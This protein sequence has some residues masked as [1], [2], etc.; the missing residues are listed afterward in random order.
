MYIHTDV[1]A[2]QSPKKLNQPC[3][4]AYGVFRDLNATTIVLADGLGS[5]VKAHIAA[6][7]C[8]SRIKG[9]VGEGAS[10]REVFK[11]VTQTMDKAWGSGDPFAV[12]TVARILNTGQATILSYEMPPPILVNPVYAQILKDRV[13][14]QKKAIIH[15]SS[16]VLSK[17]EG[18]LLMSDGITQAGIGGKFLYGW[19]SEGVQ[20]YVESKLNGDRVDGEELVAQVHA[21]GRSYW[22]VGKGDDCS[23]VLGMNR[24]GVIVNLVCGPPQ[25]PDRDSEFAHSF[26]R[27][28]GIHI[29][30]GGTTAK[31][32]ANAAHK[33]LDVKESDS[34]VTP[35]AYKIDGFEMVTEGVV[36]LNQVYHLM[37]EG[38]SDLPMDN[39]AGELAWYLRMAD[40]IN[41]WEGTA[42]NIGHGQIE[43]KLQG[44][45]N[46][47]QILKEL[48]DKLQEQGKLIVHEKW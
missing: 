19:E 42:S 20:H 33:K 6:T 14:T 8:V 41:I 46:R 10:I 9:L 28:E 26:L 35:P 1:F 47:T 4:D 15:E 34:P 22:P 30:C 44:I 13:Y 39:V 11:S 38:I 12:F 5:G 29:V 36:T 21:K 40:R 2:F 32:I 45:F 17:D 31:I 3:G 43:F 18:I 25:S 16:C 7:M 48:A 27:S 37:D 24:R 23:V